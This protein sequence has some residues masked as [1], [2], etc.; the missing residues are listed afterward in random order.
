MTTP[1]HTIHEAKL[2][3]GCSTLFQD[4]WSLHTAKEL[5]STNS[6]AARLPA[7]HAVRADTQTNGRGRTGRSWISDQG[8]LWLSAVLPCP[9]TSAQWS[10][11][12]LAAGWAIMGA[13]KDLEAA[14]LRLRW[15][16]DIM[17]GRRKL[18]G[19]LVE[20][21]AP[22]TAVIGI[23]LNV[24]NS[25]ES[26]DS[27]LASTTTRLADL[28]PSVCELDDLTHLVLRSIRRAHTLVLQ[29][30]FR[31]IADDLNTQWSIPRLVAISLNGH[32]HPFTG[33]FTGIDNEG[34]LQVT[35]DYARTCYEPSQVALLR[36][37][38]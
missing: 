14:G 36:E 10:L 9:N 25:P 6:A 5:C 15:P 30:K 34:R 22:D 4:G 18:A 3:K 11:L 13:L 23:G 33:L 17:A 1:D 38:E 12:P 26:F 20:R 19:L 7:W 27:S 16:N 8:G 29:G 35:T 28:V 21:Y 2:S 37:L 31:V 32:A 24:L